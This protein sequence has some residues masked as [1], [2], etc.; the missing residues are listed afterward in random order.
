[1]VPSK[2]WFNSE[3]P[4]FVPPGHVWLEGDNAA[5][6]TDSRSYG[7][8]PLAMVHGRVFYKVW[9]S[10]GLHS[11][12]RANIANECPDEN[13]P[14]PFLFRENLNENIYISIFTSKDI[15]EFKAFSARSS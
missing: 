9:S 12:I 7:P 4:E 6:S 3:R 10:P 2:S 5:N 14:K 11:L 13:L 1:M 15:L 8:I